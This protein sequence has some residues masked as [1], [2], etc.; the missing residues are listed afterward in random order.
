MKIGTVLSCLTAMVAATLFSQASAETVQTGANVFNGRPY[1]WLEAENYNTITNGDPNTGWK[2][3]DT[4]NPINS[5][6]GLPILLFC[7]TPPMF[8]VPLCSIKSVVAGIRCNT[9]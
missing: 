9:K 3:V 7:Q 6:S 2:V 4:E 8:Q 1:L 5:V